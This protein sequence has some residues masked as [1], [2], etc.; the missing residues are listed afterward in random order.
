MRPLTRTESLRLWSCFLLWH[1]GSFILIRP[2]ASFGSAILASVMLLP[3]DFIAARLPV[4]G[5]HKPCVL[6]VLGLLNAF[7]WYFGLRV[8]LLLIR[9][10]IK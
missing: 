4:V 1:V 7:V 6:I 5:V 10:T 3:G 2:N 9:H 8:V